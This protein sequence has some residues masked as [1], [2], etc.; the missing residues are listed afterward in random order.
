MSLWNSI[1]PLHSTIASRFM[2]LQAMGI[3][4]PLFSSGCTLFIFSPPPQ[5]QPS[6]VF[7][8]G[9]RAQQFVRSL[10]GKNMR[11]P[12]HEWHVSERWSVLVAMETQR[13][14]FRPAWCHSDRIMSICT[15]ILH[16]N[17]PYIWEQI[18]HILTLSRLGR[19][20]I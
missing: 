16:I 19:M 8:V 11:R 5:G 14:F 18:G 6:S 12:D 9:C 10:V 1:H 20:M 7:R 17:G 3:V 15:L 4:Q 13:S 2:T